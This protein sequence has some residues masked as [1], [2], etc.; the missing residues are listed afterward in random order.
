MNI[1]TKGALA[2]SLAVPRHHTLSELAWVTA[3]AAV[4]AAGAQG[5]I[6]HYPVPFTL[7]TLVVLL[8]GAFLG[9]RNG[10]LSQLLYLGVGA[11]GAPVFAG[12]SGGI[13]PLLGPTGGYLVAFPVAAAIIGFLTP[14]RRTF[15]TVLVSMGAGLLVIFLSGTLHLY[16]FFLHDWTT[17]VGSG[18]LIFSWWD[19]MKLFAAATLYYELSKRWPRLPS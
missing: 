3:F 9:A 19:L 14:R 5:Q 4:T 18:L 13:G 12:W 17:A 11:L 1:N 15:V 10:A 16:A 6:P 8:A 2:P 7:Q